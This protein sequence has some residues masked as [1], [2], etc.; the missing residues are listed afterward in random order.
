MQME[1]YFVAEKNILLGYG[2]ELV[3]EVAS[4]QEIY[5]RLGTRNRLATRQEGKDC[6]LALYVL[7]F[8][9]YNYVVV[10]LN[11]TFMFCDKTPTLTGRFFVGV[12]PHRILY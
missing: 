1:I 10:I 9:I 8:W 12:Y 4:L 6:L 5:W 3:G 2:Y 7:C 11:T